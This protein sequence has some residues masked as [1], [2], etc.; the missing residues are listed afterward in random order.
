MVDVYEHGIAEGR[1]Y[2]YAQFLERFIEICRNHHSEGRALAFAF[3]LYDF[4]SPQIFK[5]LR[6]GDYWRALNNISG[7]YISVF[8]LHHSLSERRGGIFPADWEGPMKSAETLLGRYFGI[9]EAPPTP[10]L[11]FFQVS[12][13]KVTGSFFVELHEKKLE[14][15]FEEVKSVLTTAVGSISRVKKENRG[16]TKEIFAL[17]ETELQQRELLLKLIGIGKRIKAVVD[18]GNWLKREL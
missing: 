7:P 14:D 8:S 2:N 13:K 12:E 17:I 18:T 6:D 1:N 10:S 4:K 11:L 16:N 9:T 3:F 5:V 15:A